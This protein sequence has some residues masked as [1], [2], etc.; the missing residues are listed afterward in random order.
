MDL[1]PLASSG[2][3]PLPMVGQSRTAIT[4]RFSYAEQMNH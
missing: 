3:V 4:Y 1:Y 2:Y